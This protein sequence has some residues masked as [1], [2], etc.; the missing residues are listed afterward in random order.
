MLPQ[1]IIS[2]FESTGVYPVNREKFPESE[3]NPEELK[4]YTEKILQGRTLAEN[5]QKSAINES[6]PSS[7]N[8]RVTQTS[9]AQ[10]PT[11]INEAEPTISSSRVHQKSV[12]MPIISPTKE[13]LERIFNKQSKRVKTDINKK[14]EHNTLNEEASA[15]KKVIPRLKQLA[16]GEVLTITEVLDRMKEQEKRLKMIKG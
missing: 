6:E 2:G 5:T 10:S 12:A 16:Y 15:E 9:T 7:S 11:S 4:L 3:F 14:T 8:S 13:E 1:T